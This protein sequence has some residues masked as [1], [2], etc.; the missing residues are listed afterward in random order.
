ME[1]SKCKCVLEYLFSAVQSHFLLLHFFF[2]VYFIFC[3]WFIVA[4]IT[5]V[6]CSSALEEPGFDNGVDGMI[7]SITNLD[8]TPEIIQDFL[9]KVD[10][11]KLASRLEEERF[12]RRLTAECEEERVPRRLAAECEAR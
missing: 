8:I 3:N 11:N 1:N 4:L 9:G 10:W 5:D 2:G 12:P 6:Y 7:S